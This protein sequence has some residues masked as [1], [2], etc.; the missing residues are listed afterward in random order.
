M[1][2]LLLFLLGGLWMTQEIEIEYKNLLTREEFDSLLT[3]LPFPK[4]SQVQTNYYFETE[5][6]ALRSQ[7]SALRIREKNGNY[8]LT[9]KEPHPEGLLETHDFLTEKEAFSWLHGNICEKPHVIKQLENLNIP[10]KELL[11]FGKLKTERREVNYKNVLIVLDISTYNGHIDYEFE[12]EAPDRESGKRL[13][14]QLLEEYHI[15]LKETP[16][17]I[18]RFFSLL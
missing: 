11:Y 9:L 16:N 8:Q 18:E 3:K 15:V 10:Y 14:H 6:F 13:F 17:K 12:L 4:D 7:S 5:D 2:L 1:M